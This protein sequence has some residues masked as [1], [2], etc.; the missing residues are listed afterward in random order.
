MS[1]SKQYYLLV[2]GLFIFI[3]GLMVIW[4]CA[5]LSRIE[6][7][8]EYVSAYTNVHAQNNSL[9]ERQSEFIN[10]TSQNLKSRVILGAAVICFLFET[11]LILS[12]RKKAL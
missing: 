10:S 3:M 12:L 8:N 11:I 1:Y 5:D 4:I 6:S 9:L 2:G 7:A